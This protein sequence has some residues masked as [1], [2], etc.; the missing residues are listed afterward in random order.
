MYSISAENFNN[1]KELRISKEYAKLSRDIIKLRD[2]I[3]QC[4]DKEKRRQL[5]DKYKKAVSVRQSISSRDP[6]DSS[7]R[8][9]KY[10]RYA[11]D[12]L[13][14]VIRT[15]T[16]CAKIK[17]DITKFMREKLHLEMS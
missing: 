12:F 5:I 14:G 16:E 6:M 1:G 8:R 9:L 3:N 2:N 17:E 11:D 13:I 10:I 7:Y 15:K 4:D